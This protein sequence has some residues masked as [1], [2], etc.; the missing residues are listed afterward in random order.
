MPHRTCLS[1]VLAVGLLVLLV[2]CT[3]LN[4]A[5]VP[6]DGPG[7]DPDTIIDDAPSVSLEPRWSRDAHRGR[8]NT[9]AWS[10]EGTL[11][12]SGATGGHVVVWDTVNHTRAFR[13]QPRLRE[14]RDRI[15][16]NM[17]DALAWSPDGALLAAGIVNYGLVVY[18]TSTWEEEA[19][20]EC[21]PCAFAQ[22]LAFSPTGDRLAL[23]SYDGAGY[24]D[25]DTWHFHQLSDGMVFTSVAWGS[26]DR[27][28][29]AGQFEGRITVWDTTTETISATV[30][31]N[32]RHRVMA[33]DHELELIA[34]GNDFDLR[35]YDA[36]DWSLLHSIG[37][38]D[39][40]APR[41]LVWNP[42][43]RTL[44]STH[45]GGA[46]VWNIMDWP[47]S[48]MRHAFAADAAD[49][50]VSLGRIV[51]AAPDGRF[52]IH[53]FATEATLA[54]WHNEHPDI[55]AAVS[56]APD[57]KALATG[58][59]MDGYVTVWDADTGDDAWSQHAYQMWAVPAWSPDGTVIATI[60]PD[61]SWNFPIRTW[62]PASG[63]ERTPEVFGHDCYSTDLVW[64][65]DARWLASGDCDAILVI[66]DA[67]S[68]EAVR[69]V[70]LPAETETVMAT[71]WSPAGDR[72]AIASLS[73]IVLVSTA[74]WAVERTLAIEPGDMWSSSI[75]FSHDGRRLSY[76]ARS[77]T[78]PN[79][80]L[81]VLDT[82]SL[83]VVA[84]MERHHVYSI[85][86]TAWSHDDAFIASIGED[87]LTI[88]SAE[89]AEA[90]FTDAGFINAAMSMRLAW[91]PVE[92]ALAIGGGDGSLTVFDVG[93][94]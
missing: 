41:N 6:D 28:L 62:E 9:V 75:A 74:T 90:V 38:F 79:F 73:S 53:D 32:A 83:D 20:I 33:W 12:A 70:E 5:T 39:V 84:E 59:A 72:I 55:V 36:R 81:V 8:V 76:G 11:I 43:E 4:R 35:I 47:S 27:L 44:V 21:R 25:R 51:T 22:A 63:T 46:R 77:A 26:D 64:S 10:P 34:M 30:D 94:P 50:L 92:H 49:V 42:S 80:T 13:S 67:S 91:S 15:F 65:T 23:A 1:L 48:T 16:A 3:G 57:G 66:W 60:G 86:A 61:E 78:S 40:G 17:I 31:G 54:T 68:G 2:A 24:F 82:A 37:I 14:G 52:S 93:T 45:A 88:W 7:D 18:D 89:T 29:A 85:H 71:R 19:F 58:G 56:W 87:E 69:V